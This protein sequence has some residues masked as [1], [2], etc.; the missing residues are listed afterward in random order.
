MQGSK[1]IQFFG[2]AAPPGGGGGGSPTGNT[3]DITDATVHG[4]SYAQWTIDSDGFLYK[5]TD[6]GAPVSYASWISPQSGMN[7]YDVRATLVTGYIPPG[8][9][10]GTWLNLGTDHTWG[11]EDSFDERCQLFIEIRLAATGSIVDSATITISTK[12]DFIDT[13]RVYEGPTP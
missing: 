8:P 10:L 2:S 6:V 7:L 3:V 1:I 12:A 13:H 11:W 4:V 9:A 5:R